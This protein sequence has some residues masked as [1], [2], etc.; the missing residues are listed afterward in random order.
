LFLGLL[1]IQLT[2]FAQISPDI[3][4]RLQEAAGVAT[5]RLDAKHTTTAVPT[6]VVDVKEVD[7]DDDLTSDHDDSGRNKLA[8]FYNVFLPSDAEDSQRQTIVDDIFA[9]QIEL[10]G[11]S[12]AIKSANNQTS[13]KGTLIKLYY[14]KIGFPV[15]DAWMAKTCAK[16]DIEAVPMKYYERAMEDVT[17]NSLQH[18]CVRHPNYHVIYVHPKGSFHPRPAQ[19]WW[20]KEGTMMASSE[21]CAKCMTN[22][23]CNVCGAR[24]A[25]IP[26]HFSG[27]FWRADCGYVK[28]L[29]PVAEIEPL[30]R[31]A[32][33]TSMNAGMTFKTNILVD[34][35]LGLNRFANEQ[36][37][38]SHPSFSP[39]RIPQR[40]VRPFRKDAWAE[41]KDDQAARRKEY[42]LLPGLLWKY[43]TIY[44]DT[45]YPPD[46]SW[47]WE[48]FPDGKEYRDAM[49]SLKSLKGAVL[50]LMYQSQ[51]ETVVGMT[52]PTSAPETNSEKSNKQSPEEA[53]TQS[54]NATD[55]TTVVLQ[56]TVV[57]STG[58]Y[59]SEPH[60]NYTTTLH[61]NDSQ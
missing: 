56:P 5:V 18:Y 54:V 49:N 41:M 2:E 14:N 20:R 37:I 26:A 35:S 8:I 38:G 1:S 12:Y 11:Q 47:I 43:S 28:D 17:L 40:G 22:S 51:S 24:F 7:D 6:A 46:N 32:F 31:E 13:E 55:K 3:R 50:Q 27:N 59:S 42:F 53:E 16:Y 10:L 48:H 23:K 34:S 58:S 30:F 61:G 15:D 57:S 4:L 45:A 44:N 9:T 25:S 60:S 33:N 29:R 39:W 21:E 52:Q 36:W 19:N